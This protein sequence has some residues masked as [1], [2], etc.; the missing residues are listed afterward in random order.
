[1]IQSTAQQKKFQGKL[2]K[3][4]MKRKSV[5]VIKIDEV[6]RNQNIN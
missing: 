3:K 5:P 1:M 6:D 4:Q 2:L